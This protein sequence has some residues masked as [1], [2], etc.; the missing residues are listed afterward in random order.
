ML[1]LSLRKIQTKLESR[2]KQK[3][4]I[5]TKTKSRRS[6]P[7]SESI[8]EMSNQLH[9]WANTHVLPFLLLLG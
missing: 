4:K 2:Q 8:L 6:R 3:T 5:Q 9:T 7:V 1:R